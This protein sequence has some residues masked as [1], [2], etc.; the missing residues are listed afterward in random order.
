M[1]TRMVERDDAETFRL[2]IAYRIIIF[3]IKALRF[4]LTEGYSI[5]QPILID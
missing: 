5:H 3:T 4:K 2:P 1:R